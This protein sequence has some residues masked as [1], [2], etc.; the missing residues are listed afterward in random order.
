M[1]AV[2][3]L[4]QIDGP[5]ASNA[6]A[7]LA[8]FNPSPEVRSRAIET[9][10]RR[11]PRDVIGRLI[12]LVRK[13]FKYEVRRPGGPGT[14]GELFVE[15]ERF[16]VHRVY[17]NPAID[18]ATIPPRLFAPWVPFD[19]YNIRNQILV[20]AAFGGMTFSP[21][22]SGPN[23]A[24]VG[25]QIAA[26]PQDAA[27]ILK[28]AGSRPPAASFNPASNLVYDTLAAAAYRDMQI[29]S[30][31]QAIEQTS[32][33]LQQRLAQD[34]QT[35]ETTNTQINDLNGRVLPVLKL[36]TG[37]D[38]GAEPEKWKTW[39][40]DQLGYVYQSNIPETKPTL[41]DIVVPF[42]TGTTSTACF[43]AGTAV[44]TLDG[45]RTIET[46]QV[47]DRVLSQDPTTGALTFQPV[48]AVHHNRPS[49]TLRIFRST[50]RRSSP[51]ASIASGRPAR[52]GSWPAT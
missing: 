12:H 23:V 43:A 31:Y 16:N 4:G 40:T 5:A 20:S 15:G 45:P 51:P 25:R 41:T 2:Q 30:R 50:A 36:I 48:V 1:A 3:M 7:A 22:N 46:I 44:S 49:A 38:L 8:V 34:I 21:P 24:Q 47:G 14:R 29:A 13:P 6:L 39:W 26:N 10:A 27:S 17:L 32:R 28:D 19:P 18:P 33:N 52:A 37:Q 11:D 9:L 42:A 35:V